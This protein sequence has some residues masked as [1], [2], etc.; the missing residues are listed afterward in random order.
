MVIAGDRHCLPFSACLDVYV[1]V[2]TA[3][4]RHTTSP[5]PFYGNDFEPSS[6]PKKKS[7]EF[8]TELGFLVQKERLGHCSL[9]FA[10][11]CTV[12]WLGWGLPYQRT[13]H[14]LPLPV[15]REDAV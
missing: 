1:E 12:Y 2:P 6:R 10:T 14:C 13:S 15:F 7:G 8:V 4:L 5:P 3:V 11:I 9:F